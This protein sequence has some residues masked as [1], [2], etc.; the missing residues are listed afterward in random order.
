MLDNERKAFKQVQKRGISVD[1]T[2]G[3]PE[4]AQLAVSM[5]MLENAGTYNYVEDG[6]DA[7]NYG[8]LLGI[9]SARE[10]YANLMSLH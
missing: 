4:S 8:Q 5:P 1:M 7:R 9:K 2:R 3:R 6:V 10:L